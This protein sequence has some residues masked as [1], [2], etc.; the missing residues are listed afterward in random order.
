MHEVSA[1]GAP[2]DR[3]AIVANPAA[4]SASPQ[5]ISAVTERTRGYAKQVDVLWTDAKGQAAELARRCAAAG[6]RP[7]DVI[8][9]IGGDGTLREVAAGLIDIT[10]AAPPPLLVLPGGTGN[11]NYRSLWDDA[12]W[13]EAL[14]AGL[15]GAGAERRFL[16][17]ARI[18][19]P[20]RLVVL[21]MSTGLFTDATAI[22]TGIAA[23]GRARYLAAIAE[24]ASSYIPYTGQ[25]MVDGSIVHEGPAVLVSVGGSRHR[26]GVL[27]VLP[28][29]LRDDG[30]L[31]V[32]VIGAPVTAAEVSGLIRSGIH[33]ER[34]GVVYARGESVTVRRLDGESLD[35][36]SDGEVV[37]SRL[38]DVTIK[39]LAH[40]LP[41]LSSSLRPGG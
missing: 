40:A 35:F 37:R 15:T 10:G 29:S 30:L 8:V 9:V 41:V 22:A 34:D 12:P 38:A 1:G 27:E 2:Y 24:A 21:G 20:P 33:L 32:C 3:I 39:V 28:H 16:D 25:V 4:G 5:F 7:A 6:A 14:A 13:H 17:L 26:A 18:A 19:D 23:P 36:E 11:S 31:D